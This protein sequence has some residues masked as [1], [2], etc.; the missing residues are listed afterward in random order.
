[1]YRY[2][3][4]ASGRGPSTLPKSC[5]PE[6]EPK[7]KPRPRPR[8]LGRAPPAAPV[9]RLT[10]L[11][12]LTLAQPEAQRRQVHLVARVQ[13]AAHRRERNVLERREL[14]L[15][16][17]LDDVLD[18]QRH[19]LLALLRAAHEAVH[20]GLAVAQHL[21]LDAVLVLHVV[22]EALERHAGAVDLEEVPGRK[23]LLLA[24]DH[25]L[26]L[27]RRT[28]LREGEYRDGEVRKAVLVGL[29]RLLLQHL[30]H[31]ERDE[32]G[33]HG[34]R[35]G[36]GGDDLAGDL[37][38]RVHVR[39]GDLVVPRAQ[40]R[41]RHDHGHLLIHVLVEIHR[42]QP[43]AGERRRRGQRVHDAAHLGVHRGAAAKRGLF[44][45]GRLLLVGG[46]L[47][48]I[49][50][51][52]RGHVNA[53]EGGDD[54]LVVRARRDAVD[55]SAQARDAADELEVDLVRRRKYQRR[56]RLLAARPVS[57]LVRVQ[58]RVRIKVRVRVRVSV[59]FRTGVRV[60]QKGAPEVVT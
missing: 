20:D 7:P 21:N 54:G 23:S 8:L 1:M 42:R 16:D 56:R 2:G 18:G 45:F 57:F 60:D 9:L 44:L 15:G 53:V 46:D 39:L 6:P 33:D 10:A 28:R 29:E 22:D 34:R 5:G 41:H 25:R 14:R 58:V 31:L 32:A 36:D 11:L 24:L 19:A 3:T 55:L 13:V 49:S 27:F 50:R 40:V 48:A 43:E 59:G 30:E 51:R 4:S 37:A 38:A 17:K 26:R 52:E 12:T 35:R 47:H